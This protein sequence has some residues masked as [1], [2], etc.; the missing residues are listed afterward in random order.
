MNPDVKGTAKLSLTGS[1]RHSTKAL[2]GF[3]KVAAPK[4]A[5]VKP[6]SVPSTCLALLNG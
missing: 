2:T 3:R 6:K 4:K 1:R 5:K